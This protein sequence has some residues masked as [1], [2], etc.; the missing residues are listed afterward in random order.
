MFCFNMFL[1]NIERDREIER[2]ININIYF[3]SIFVFKYVYIMFDL[4]FINKL[5]LYICIWIILV[6]SMYMIIC[7]NIIFL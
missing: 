3:G 1:Y 7:N 2:L 6:C 4:I 5:E